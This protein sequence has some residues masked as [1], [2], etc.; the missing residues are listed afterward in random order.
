[1]EDFVEGIVAAFFS[2]IAAGITFVLVVIIG[3]GLI[4]ALLFKLRLLSNE[5]EAWFGI[6]FGVPAG[7]LCGLLVFIYCFRKIRKYGE[8]E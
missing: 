5:G 8:P 7:V 1:M 4:G 6:S 2:I 3:A